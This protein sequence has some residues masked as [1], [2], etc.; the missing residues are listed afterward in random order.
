MAVASSL[1]LESAPPVTTAVSQS[2]LELMLPG[3]GALICTAWGC[4]VAEASLPSC[5]FRASIWPGERRILGCVQE[6]GLSPP[7]RLQ[8]WSQFPPSN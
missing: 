1:A 8:P 5:A 4:L 6:A 7:G 2:A 3:L